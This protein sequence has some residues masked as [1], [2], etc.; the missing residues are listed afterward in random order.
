[1]LGAVERLGRA[2]RQR[3]ETGKRRD[4]RK[5]QAKQ[6]WHALALGAGDARRVRRVSV[7]E[8]GTLLGARLSQIRQELR[9]QLR[10][11]RRHQEWKVVAEAPLLI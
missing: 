10:G 4:R 3:R 6:A 5:L 1:M 9:G 8:S 2:A 11:L 7:E